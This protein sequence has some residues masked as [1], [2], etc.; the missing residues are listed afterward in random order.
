MALML[1][2]SGSRFAQMACGSRRSMAAAEAS[3]MS[4]DDLGVPVS[5]HLLSDHQNDREKIEKADHP[6]LPH[7][8]IRDV[9]SNAGEA[10][11]RRWPPLSSVAD[12]A[13]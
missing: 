12:P 5:F 10:I 1:T 7:G 6:D 8:H 4:S 11:R 3:S 9:G 2:S 13:I